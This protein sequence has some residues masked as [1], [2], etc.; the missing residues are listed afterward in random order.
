MT[1]RSRPLLALCTLSL[2]LAS[3]ACGRKPSSSL[4]P[5]PAA[6]AA[7]VLSPSEIPADTMI[8]L[9]RGNCYGPCP[10]YTL[11]I[12]ADGHVTFEGHGSLFP[13]N[14]PM[15][16]AGRGTV[17]STRLLAL[18]Q[19]IQANHVFQM[20]DR[21]PHAM[22]DMSTI[23]LTVTMGGKT[24]TVVWGG[25]EVKKDAL[26]APKPLVEIWEEID[27]VAETER[28]ITPTK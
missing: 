25:G 24:K 6:S 5:D 1:M 28:W 10:S 19:E 23:T 4:G 2:S 18:V 3:L 16:D 12:V 14:P 27:R 21:Y 11:T 7:T 26:P 13:R 9:E 20:A 22:Y 15:A 8:V 17:A